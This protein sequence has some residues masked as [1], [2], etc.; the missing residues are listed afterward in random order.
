MGSISRI[1]REAFFSVNHIYKWGV[2]VVV[3]SFFLYGCVRSVPVPSA[4]LRADHATHLANAAGWKSLIIHTPDFAFKAYGPKPKIAAKTLTIYIEGDG[5]AWISSDTPSANPTPII[6]M[7]LEIA[8]HDQ[9]HSQVVYLARPCQFVFGSEWGGCRPE[10]WTRLRFSPEIIRATNQAV[11]GLKN[12]YHA[13]KVI[14]IGYSG[15]GAVAALVAARRTDVD[16]LITIAGNLDIEYWARQKSLTPL[17]GSLNPADAW[18][19]LAS[20]PQTHWVGGRDTV[21]PK[22]VAFAY[23]KR[24]PLSH[25]PDIKVMPTF[26]H[27]CCWATLQV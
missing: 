8:I 27:A 14:L 4:E 13:R 17:S 15:G 22:E 1:Y 26:D 10:Y 11:D 16:R 21:V 12:R 18:E 2:I 6:P 5:L 20:I 19:A 9:K 25:Q 7:G 24:F 23:V 3:A